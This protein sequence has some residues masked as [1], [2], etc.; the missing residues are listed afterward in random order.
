MLKIL[1]V[2]NIVESIDITGIPAVNVINTMYRS[3][4][5]PMCRYSMQNLQSVDVDN[6]YEMR[7]MNSDRQR[8]KVARNKAN[9]TK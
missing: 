1:I 3:K 6:Y 5:C 9:I 8:I 4:M 7:E 2:V